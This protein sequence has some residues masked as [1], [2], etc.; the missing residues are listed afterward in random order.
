MKAV[1]QLKL[2]RVVKGAVPA[3]AYQLGFLAKR[4]SP[5]PAPVSC[6]PLNA[7]V[8]FTCGLFGRDDLTIK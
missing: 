2:R 4:R 6:E 3:E 1:K 5:E 7:L 8:D